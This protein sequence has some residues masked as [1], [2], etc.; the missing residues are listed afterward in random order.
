M[1]DNQPK[2]IV[3]WKLLNILQRAN[4][5]QYYDN[6]IRQGKC[7]VERMSKVSG[8]LKEAI[9]SVRMKKLHVQI[10]TTA[11]EEA[12]SDPDLLKEVP[13]WLK[14]SSGIRNQPQSQ[15]SQPSNQ[16]IVMQT[17]SASIP[18]Q[19]KI[20]DYNVDE[21]VSGNNRLKHFYSDILTCTILDKNVLDELI[22][23]C[24][25]TIDDREEIIKPASQT[26][27]NKILLDLLISRPYDLL[28]LFIVILK[29][30][31]PDNSN[32]QALVSKMST[33]D[34][35]TLTLNKG[36]SSIPQQTET[37]TEENEYKIRLQKNFRALTLNM[38]CTGSISDYLVEREVLNLEDV[39]EINCLGLTTHESN[40]RLLAKM[41]RKDRLAYAIFIQ[42]LKQD[43]SN[44]ELA[45]QIDETIIT[46]EERVMYTIGATMIHKRLQMKAYSVYDVIPQ[47]I[48]EHMKFR[49]EEWEKDDKNFVSTKA[50]EYALELI[51]KENVVTMTGNPGTGKSFTARHVA[52]QMKKRGYFIIPVNKPEDIQNYYKLGR[53]TIFVIDDICGRFCLDQHILI[54]WKQMISVIKT[55][56]TDKC[57]KIISSCRLQVFN[58][59]KFSHLTIF[60]LCECN[61]SSE[62]LL[63]TSKERSNIATRY[64]IDNYEKELSTKY[65]F[66]PWLCSSYHLNKSTSFNNFL[67]NPF[68]VF[69]VEINTFMSEGKEGKLKY[70]GLVLV[71]LFDNNLSEER[72]VAKDKHI[73][74]VIE[75]VLT[76][77]GLNRGTS[78]HRLKS[79]LRSLEGWLLTIQD[80]TFKIV[81]DK[82][83]DF[84]SKQ[85][86]EKMIQLFSDNSATKFISERFLL[87]EIHDHMEDNDFFIIVPEKYHN[88]FIQRIIKDWK[89]GELIASFSNSNMKYHSFRQR[90]LSNLQHMPQ[91]DQQRL[92]NVVDKE[93]QINCVFL[94][95][96]IDDIDFLRWALTQNANVNKVSEDGSSVLFVASSD[97]QVH[98]I[99]ELITHNADV[100]L[101]N[102]NGESPLHIACQNGHTPAV[103]ELLKHNP[104]LN[105][106]DIKGKT[107][108]YS[109]CQNNHLS[110]VRELLKHTE[111]DLNKCTIKGLS[112]LSIAE[113]Q[114]YTE[115]AIEL[116]KHLLKHNTNKISPKKAGGGSFNQSK[117]IGLHEHTCTATGMHGYSKNR[118]STSLKDNNHLSRTEALKMK[119]EN[120]EFS[121]KMTPRSRQSRCN[122]A[123]SRT[124]TDTKDGVYFVFNELDQP[125]GIEQV[126]CNSEAIDVIDIHLPLSMQNFYHFAASREQ[127]EQLLPACKEGSFLL[128]LSQSPDAPYSLTVKGP[129][130]LPIHLRISMK[131]G[132]YIIGEMCLRFQSV[133]ALIYHYTKQ[134]IKVLTV[135]HIKLIWPIPRLK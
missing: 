32:V 59:D 7:D 79:S 77:C 3:E 63:L 120:L 5:I 71:V 65:D 73:M 131:D 42:A 66:F 37:V 2:T 83:F 49:L 13:S 30:S 9:D 115:V 12:M 69:K 126:L 104:D 96:I 29:Q 31:D 112:P 108:I 117:S 20:E 61:L 74:R 122:N 8:F 19:K 125:I 43:I 27:R 21:H 67:N 15:I 26:E 114:G 135:G 22:S 119:Y 72:L 70:C 6:F 1:A 75:E 10:F 45:K 128:R 24:I 64:G 89:N 34:G 28:N 25:L 109:A 44:K 85:F 50:G 47:H 134:T 41:L 98:I 100:N 95:C 88:C 105:Q 99:K 90:F 97:G 23:R 91:H 92:V 129:K 33:P 53:K 84:L 54:A 18:T 86:G 39:Q 94:C 132:M 87:T 17:L 127:A 103:R 4:L 106:H 46:R 133:P 118:I 56:V 82:L 62:N 110:V 78:E 52:L 121:Q 130:G 38:S 60:K 40:R 81:H 48:K 11:L 124:E 36:N 101:C 123:E 102:R 76:E 14:T 57:C 111:L 55:F 68:E 116:T 93:F 107:A 51:L 113:N 35:H 80:N 16:K 58:D